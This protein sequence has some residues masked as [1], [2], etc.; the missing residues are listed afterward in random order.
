MRGRGQTPW[1]SHVLMTPPTSWCPRVAQGRVGLTLA[2]ERA[3]A[4]PKAPLLCPAGQ[5]H[6]SGVGGG[7]LCFQVGTFYVHSRWRAPHDPDGA[8]RLVLMVPPAGS[9]VCKMDVNFVNKDHTDRE[10]LDRTVCFSPESQPLQGGR[11]PGKSGGPESGQGTGKSTGPAHA[12]SGHRLSWPG[13]PPLSPNGCGLVSPTRTTK[14]FLKG[15]AVSKSNV[16]MKWCY[17]MKLHVVNQG[18]VTHKQIFLSLG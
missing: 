7:G 8:T 15:S 1:K 18:C 9:Q 10:H 17:H 4:P 16:G 11:G 5:P 14:C 6:G 3:P 12:S 2:R 13:L